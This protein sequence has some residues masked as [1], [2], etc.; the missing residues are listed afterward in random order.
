MI[1]RLEVRVP[2]TV[3]KKR[4]FWSQN[5]SHR[6][7]G[8]PYL[9]VLDGRKTSLISIYYGHSVPMPHPKQ[10]YKVEFSSTS[11]FSATDLVSSIRSAFLL[12]VQDALNLTVARIDLTADV[13]DV[14]VQWFKQHCRVKRKQK[15]KTYDSVQ[16]EYEP[17]KAETAA[18]VTGLEFGRRPD[19]Y[20]IYNRVAETLP[21]GD[22]LSFW[23]SPDLVLTRVERQCSGP[24]VPPRLKTLGLLFENGHLIDPFPNLICSSRAPT[25]PD[26]D[27]WTPRKWLMSLGLAYAVHEYGEAAVRSRLDRHRNANRTFRDYSDLLDVGPLG[28]TAEDLRNLY[29]VSTIA[30]LNPPSRAA[31]APYKYSTRLPRIPASPPDKKHLITTIQRHSFKRVAARRKGLEVPESVFLDTPQKAKRR[32]SANATV[33]GIAVPMAGPDE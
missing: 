13:P 22:A 6:V 28:P 11:L 8:G 27:R 12:S 30:Q 9:W 5:S 1:D 32:P 25:I 7:R 29:R 19:F 2:S 24:S 21:R 20:R 15:S 18:G 10:H 16:P 3:P 31:D 26:M 33:A 4:W 14:Q 23:S 17:L